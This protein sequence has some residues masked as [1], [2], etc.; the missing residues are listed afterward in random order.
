MQVRHLD[1]Y[2]AS[3]RGEFPNRNLTTDIT[4]EKGYMPRHV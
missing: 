2:A 1:F 3:W 4:G